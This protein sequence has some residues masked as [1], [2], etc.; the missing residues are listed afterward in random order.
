[1]IFDTGHFLVD[2]HPS[3]PKGRRQRRVHQVTDDTE[4]QLIRIPQ[5][6][7]RE[8][9]LLYQRIL[10]SSKGFNW[11][12]PVDKQ[13]LLCDGSIFSKHRNELHYRHRWFYDDLLETKL[14]SGFGKFSES[15]AETVISKLSETDGSDGVL[16]LNQIVLGNVLSMLIDLSEVN[17]GLRSLVEEIKRAVD[18]LKNDVVESWFPRLSV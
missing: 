15:A 13:S 9:W 8:W 5:I 16:I 3:Q 6:G 10:R 4:I 14:V 7:H 17:K 12:F 18:A 1:M 2:V 11:R